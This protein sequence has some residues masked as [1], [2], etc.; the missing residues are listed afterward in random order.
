MKPLRLIALFVA[1]TLLL[2]CGLAIASTPPVTFEPPVYYTTGSSNWNTI[3]VADLNG[4]HKPDLVLGNADS[5]GILLGNGD[6]TF[7]PF[8]TY[9]GGAEWLAVVD[10]DKN[11][12]LDVVG[13][14]PDGVNV[15]LG[16]G[17][18]TFQTAINTKVTGSGLGVA[19]VNHDGKLDVTMLGG[20][21]LIVLPGNGDGTFKAPIGTSVSTYGGLAVADLNHDGYPDAVVT[22]YPGLVSPTHRIDATIGVMLGNGDG[23]FQTPVSYDAG[24]YYPAQLTITDLTGDGTPDVLIVNSLG[25]SN[26]TMGGVDALINDGAGHFYPGFWDY[27]GGVSAYAAAVGDLNGDG[28]SD[29]VVAIDGHISVSLFEG[30]LREHPLASQPEVVAIAD[31]NG[32]GQPDIVAATVCSNPPNG[33][34]AGAAVVLLNAKVGSKTAVASSLNPS[35]VAQAVTFTATTSSARGPA[36]DGITVSFFDGTKSLGSGVT[37]GGVAKYTTSSL[38]AGT[39]TIKAKFPGCIFVNPSTGTLSQTVNP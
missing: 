19:D 7:Q 11:G 30:Q 21:G 6:G 39:H 27:P 20:P 5:I 17:N 1:P 31:L 16:N 38:A 12:T 32:D 24:G 34:T 35:K 25:H 37:S 3:A 29:T 15:F 33:C 28:L 23:T 13:V 9:A 14:G 8:V 18:G 10:I 2:L 36:P 22:T 4:D 26:H